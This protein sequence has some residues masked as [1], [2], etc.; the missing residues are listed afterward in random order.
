MNFLQATSCLGVDSENTSPAYPFLRF[1]SDLSNIS[2][3]G[4]APELS[5]TYSDHASKGPREV[6]LML[7]PDVD[8]HVKHT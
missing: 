4:V 6:V 7:K 3:L 2:R 8:A 5:G 1:R